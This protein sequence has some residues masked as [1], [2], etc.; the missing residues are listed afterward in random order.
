MESKESNVNKFLMWAATQTDQDFKEYG[1]GGTF[2]KAKLAQATTI[3]RSAFDQNDVLKAAVEALEVDLRDKEVF[4]Q[5]SD[6]K[7]LKTV[8]PY[9][10]DST[11]RS[12]ESKRQSSLEAENIELKA[13]IGS[14]ESRLIK[15]ERLEDLSQT[16]L[17]LGVIPQ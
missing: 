11:R 3:G 1:L 10:Q 8:K 17:D 4:A 12:I 13:R 15:Y 14:L 9:D 7:S 5:K 16:L 2:N 6:T